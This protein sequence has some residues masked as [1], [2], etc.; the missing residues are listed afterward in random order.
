MAV[1]I[2]AFSVVV[3]NST[4]EAKYPGGLAQYE[5][6]RPNATFCADE[7]L[8][9]VGFMDKGDADFFAAELAAKGLTPSRDGKAEDVALVTSDGPKQ[10]CD[11]LA[12]ARWENVTIAWLAGTDPG[13]LYA[14]VGWQP[15]QPLEWMSDDEKKE[16][17]EYLRSEEAVDVYRHKLSGK[18]VYVGRTRGRNE[19]HETRHNALYQEACDLIKGLIIVEDVNPPPLDAT[20]RQRLA[21]A[22]PLFEEATRIRP[23]NWAAMWLLGKVYQRL[24][25]FER[26]LSWFARAHRVNPDHVDV[27][28][29]ASIAAMEA[30]RPTD[31]V[32]YA[33]RALE[34]QPGNP[35][36]SC[37]LALALLLS[38]KPADARRVAGEALK[39]DPRDKIIVH[40]VSII[41]EVIKG[42]RPCPHHVRDLQ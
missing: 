17:L 27:A 32:E 34:I 29:E 5:A 37:N 15:Q 18:E 4:L 6:D 35:G 9:R 42:K 1:P 16:R 10:P 28:R 31:A 22:I 19:R 13:N 12:L 7:H 20:G 26:S 40:V 11:W 33:G 38:E 36:L 24:T 2:E 14:P 25:D 39:K 41:D 21:R 30:G 3:R 23:G 8:S